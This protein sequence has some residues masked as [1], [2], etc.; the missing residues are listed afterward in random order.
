MACNRCN[1]I[2]EVERDHPR[3]LLLRSSVLVPDRW[4]SGRFRN[5]VRSNSI[6]N[7]AGEPECGF[8]SYFPRAVHRRRI[9]YWSRNFAATRRCIQRRFSL[10][11]QWSW[12]SRFH[13]TVPLWFAYRVKCNLHSNFSIT[14][15]CTNL[16]RIN[17]SL[18]FKIIWQPNGRR[19]QLR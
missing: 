16:Q 3:R 13:I 19:D 14:I 7:S 15:R 6:I 2:W 11:S 17:T 1:G 10:P 9:I 4:L 18:A 5:S 12:N 8:E